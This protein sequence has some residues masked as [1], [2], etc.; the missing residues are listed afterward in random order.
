MD[1][2]DGSQLI[3]K[4][5]YI[6]KDVIN[7]PIE[8]TV[9]GKLPINKFLSLLKEEWFTKIEFSAGISISDIK[10]NHQRL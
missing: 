7:T 6:K 10:Y 8:K 3:G 1:L 9:W 2:Q 4:T 5:N